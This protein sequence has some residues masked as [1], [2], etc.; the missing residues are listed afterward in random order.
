VGSI[1]LPPGAR[2]YL[3]T[4]ALIYAVERNPTLWPLLQPIWAAAHAGTVRLETSALT[5]LEVL[6]GPLKSGNVALAS[7]YDSLLHSR[8]LH[9]YPIDDAVLREAARL[10]S[11]VATLR[12]PDAIH[13]ATALLNLPDTC[14]TNDPGF[15]R[16]PGLPVT[17]L[18][19]LLT[20]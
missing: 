9:V 20:P 5:L 4:S 12:T 1:A 19:D 14:L 13:A 16:V 18:S 7:T 2:L 8:D 17:V 6:V 11:I 15:R 10:R 3:D